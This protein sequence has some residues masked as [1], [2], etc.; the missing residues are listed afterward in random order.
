V[1]QETVY[2]C[3]MND[4]PPAEDPMKCP[5]CGMQMV[6]QEAQEGDTGGMQGH[7]DHGHR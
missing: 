5:K 1:S 7:E 4:S 2:A 6:P 3:P